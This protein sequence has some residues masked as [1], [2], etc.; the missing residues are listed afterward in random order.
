[1]TT[2][3]KAQT[4]V[5]LPHKVSVQLPA[6]TPCRSSKHPNFPVSLHKLKGLKSKKKGRKQTPT[7]KQTTFK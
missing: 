1:M 2:E 6:L 7:G 5:T 4:H 3:E